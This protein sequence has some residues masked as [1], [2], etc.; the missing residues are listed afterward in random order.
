MEFGKQQPV[1]DQLIAACAPYVDPEAW[2]IRVA[3]EAALSFA[4][5]DAGRTELIVN[6]RA[7]VLGIL[8]V[9]SDPEY[10]ERYQN[11]A[12]W[13]VD[14]LRS[15]TPGQSIEETV[16]KHAEP[17][18]PPRDWK[19]KGFRVAPSKT[20]LRLLEKASRY[21]IR[22]MDRRTAGLRHV[23]ASLVLD[24]LRPLGIRDL[25][26]NLARADAEDLAR[27]LVE[28]IALDLDRGES[29]EAWRRLFEAAGNVETV[30][31]AVD[32]AAAPTTPSPA[33]LV[34][35]FAADRT[36]EGAEDPLGTRAD[37]LA[38]ARLA[39]HEDAD[40][41]ISIGI[42]GGWGS[43]K[44]T[45]ME[46]L[47]RHIRALADPATAGDQP[48]GGPRFVSP[49]V[50]IRFNAWQFADA[51][52]WASLTAEF[53]DQLR[54]G[55]FEGGG[56]RAHARLIEDVNE[57]V[58]GLSKEATAR[59]S[60][61]AK[62][63]EQLRTAQAAHDS[64]VEERHE[65]VRQAMITGMVAAYD[66]N[67]ADLVRVG[68]IDPKSEDQLAEFIKLAKDVRTQAGRISR[69][70][71]VLLRQWPLVLALSTA[72]L[73]LGLIAFGVTRWAPA[74]WFTGVAAAAAAITPVLRRG[75]GLVRE[76]SRQTA[77][78]A[79]RIEE[80]ESA[81]L[82]DVLEK[83]VALRSAAEEAE[84]VREASE[85]AD[86]SLARYVDPSARSNPPRVLRYL[87]EDDPDTKAFEKEIGLIGRARRLFEALDQIVGHNREMKRRLRNMPSAP[88]EPGDDPNR[89]ERVRLVSQID[90]EIPDRIILYIDDLDRCT[91]DQVY[92][93]LQAVHLMLAFR[94]FVV[95]VAVD[96]EWVEAAVASSIEFAGQDS[97][98]EDV[99]NK[100]RRE[101]AIE[102]LSKIFQLPFWLKPFSGDENSRYA[103]YVRS[104]TRASAALNAPAPGGPASTPTGL[105][106]AGQDSD[107][108]ASRLAA[109]TPSAPRSPTVGGESP[110]SS[111]GA[112]A[113][114]TSEA[115]VRALRTLQLDIAEEKFLA[116]PAI[117]ALAATDP[118]G[119]K[120]L[121]NVYKIARARL[122]ETDEGMILGGGAR[123]PAYP[124]IA[125]CAALETGQPPDQAD[126]IYSRLRLR[127]QEGPIGKLSAQWSMPGVKS[128][129]AAAIMER[130]GREATLREVLEIARVV[131]RYSFN[132]Y[133]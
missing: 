37:V 53:F 11:S 109:P 130:G 49:I 21:A 43:G 5:I 93:V 15:R 75:I 118:R 90:T 54:A 71:G 73:V 81:G 103:E 133:H 50:Q 120:R 70:G 60:A 63:D 26:W 41:P 98:N 132:K 131:R 105:P 16:R 30:G 85:R 57:H 74:G 115:V 55:G 69:T 113:E 48:D 56:K 129:F 8:A 99:K 24:N 127:E 20:V 64:A 111:P 33:Y 51:N 40:P 34:S 18:P 101:R 46:A 25:G 17:L 9:G 28:H 7:L 72:A 96:M 10:R 87:L 45:F 112:P 1:L 119:V 124:L 84:A 62:A 36:R 107:P 110:T 39:C 126:E 59:R 79:D 12:T 76:V 22:T 27:H 125:V 114:T 13:F 102:Y 94:L 29:I 89:A 80:A 97:E 77:P 100:A 117:Q 61:L 44:S 32:N 108:K 128:A 42:F 116:S 19:E 95:V 35:G 68:V 6:Y 58:R 31:S 2:G 104:L 82:R 52:L 106:S 4:W 121:V 47:Q 23:L 65:G 3:L 38:L 83:E 122:S 86:R 14:W 92:K 78:F 88:A 66:R 123:P 91:H 67:R